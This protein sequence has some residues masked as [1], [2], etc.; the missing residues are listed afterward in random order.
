MPLRHD[1]TRLKLGH[2]NSSQR[3]TRQYVRF[4]RWL[5]SANGKR[6]YC[7]RR[8]PEDCADS[9]IAMIHQIVEIARC[10]RNFGHCC[11]IFGINWPYQLSPGIRGTIENQLQLLNGVLRNWCVNGQ[12]FVALV[13]MACSIISQLETTRGHT[14]NRINSGYSYR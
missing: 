13:D 14:V 10:T 9:N 1:F 3:R 4:Q 8:S 7:R 2:E 11:S 5:Y 12:K 6:T